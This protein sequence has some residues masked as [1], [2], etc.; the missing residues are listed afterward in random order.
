MNVN[1]LN[2]KGK[3]MNLYKS[4]RNIIIG[5]IM[6]FGLLGATTS[7]AAQYKID[8]SHS[9]IEFSVSNFGAGIQK[10]QFNEFS[11]EFGFGGDDGDVTKIEIDMESIDSNWAARDKHLR[12]DDFFNSASFPKAT[13]V[14]T[15]VVYDGDK[16][17]MTGDLTIRDVTK[18]VDV[19]VVKLGA[20][21]DRR[22]NEVAGFKGEFSINRSEYNVSMNLGPHLEKVTIIL[23]INGVKK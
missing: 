7:L 3:I 5:G 13:F 10:G 19:D 14:S 12:S 23:Y 17:T 16:I 2:H 11:G 22:G 8:R 20:G 18:S 4:T 15:G 21:K 6:G 9:A 1:N